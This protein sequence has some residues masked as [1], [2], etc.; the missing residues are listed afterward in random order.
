M[1]R[2][3]DDVLSAIVD[4]EAPGEMRE[5]IVYLE[6]GRADAR[7][8][9]ALEGALKATLGDVRAAVGDWPKL[10]AAM[11]EDADR[12]ADERSRGAAALVR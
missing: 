8:R 10:Q 7:Q 11:A 1:R 2:N 9:R 4:G 5:S 3:G 12:L 6:T